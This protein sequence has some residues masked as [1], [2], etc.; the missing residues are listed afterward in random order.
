MCTSTELSGGVLIGSFAGRFFKGP[1]FAAAAATPREKDPHAV[2]PAAACMVF[3]FRRLPRFLALFVQDLT[4][5]TVWFA[6]THG[7]DLDDLLDAVALRV[8]VPK[9]CFCLVCHRAVV[10]GEND[11]LVMCG[12]VRGCALANLGDPAEWN[13][14]PCRRGGCW[15]TNSSCFRCGLTGQ[16]SEAAIPPKGGPPPPPN[17]SRGP[18]VLRPASS[19][20]Q[21]KSPHHPKPRPLS[22]RNQAGK[23]AQNHDPTVTQNLVDLLQSPGVSQ[24]VVQK[25]QQAMQKSKLRVVEEKE[26]TLYVF[27]QKIGQANTHFAHVQEETQKKEREYL[28]AID[29]FEEQ[30]SLVEQLEKANWEAPERLESSSDGEEEVAPDAS[31]QEEE[32]QD[33]EQ[34]NVYRRQY[35]QRKRS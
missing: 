35:G 27:K 28:A 32:D 20:T 9:S 13:C 11:V 22:Q 5:K 19:R 8:A 6:M 30:K 12:R 7:C 17:N 4:G 33:T 15:V 21:A 14:A 18:V 24:Q 23:G 1:S 10:P 31:M 16:E 34:N 26:H 2:A 25:V 3:S 29:R